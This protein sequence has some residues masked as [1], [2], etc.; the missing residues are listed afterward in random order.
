[1]QVG[2]MES[3]CKAPGTKRLT[4]EYD[5][6]LSSFAFKF[7]SRRYPSAFLSAPCAKL[8]V[9]AG[10]DRLD[11]LLTVAQMQVGPRVAPRHPVP[12]HFYSFG[13]A[14]GVYICSFIIAPQLVHWVTTPSAC[15]FLGRLTNFAPHPVCARPMYVCLYLLRLPSPPTQAVSSLNNATHP[16]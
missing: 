1:M 9:L 16:T 3:M 2:P 10:T 6:L 7:N 4:L 15:A 8:L 12:T 14:K 13:K 11:T 5:K